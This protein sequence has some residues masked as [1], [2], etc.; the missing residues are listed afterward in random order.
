MSDS[1]L[2]QFIPFG[3]GYGNPGLTIR[4]DTADELAAIFDDLASKAD[5]EETSKLDRILDGVMLVNA[6]V[7]LKGLSVAKPEVKTQATTHPQAS[8]APSSTPSCSHGD[9]KWKEGVSK[10]GNNYKGWF[11]NAPYGQTKCAA[12]FIK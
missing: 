10:A 11:C 1:A 12:Q 5:G 9:M 2:T 8:S 7:T 4:A 6:G 3:A